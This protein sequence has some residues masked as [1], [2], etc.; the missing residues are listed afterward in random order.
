[1]EDVDVLFWNTGFR[2]A[3]TH[4]APLQLRE[5]GGGIRM[6]DDVTVAKDPRVLLVGYG[7]T[8]STVGANRAGRLAGRAAARVLV[9]KPPR[10][11]AV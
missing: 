8:A 9:G 3:L 5:P 7:S 1:T 10:R 4:L 6:T 2:P 11:P